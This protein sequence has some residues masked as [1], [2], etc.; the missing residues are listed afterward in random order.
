MYINGGW[1]D[2]SLPQGGG[3]YIIGGTVTVTDTNIYSNQATIVSGPFLELSPDA[4]A[5]ET[6]PNSP[7]VS[8]FL[9]WQGGGVSIWSTVSFDS[10]NIYNNTA[11]YVRACLWNLSSDAPARRRYQE[12]TV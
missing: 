3:M 10:C 7:N 12:L 2:P 4:P 9:V 11:G 1:W 8:T 5:E 6:S